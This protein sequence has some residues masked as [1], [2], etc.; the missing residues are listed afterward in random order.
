MTSLSRSMIAQQRQE[1]IQQIV[2]RIRRDG[3][4]VVPRPLTDRLDDPDEH[5][6]KFVARIEEECRAALEGRRPHLEA[7]KTLACELKAEI[8]RHGWTIEWDML[9][10]QHVIVAPME[11]VTCVDCCGGGRQRVP[12]KLDFTYSESLV[13]HSKICESCKGIGKQER[14][15]DLAP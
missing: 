4:C 1:L 3:S 8:E 15:K 9:N 5:P 14:R 13:C 6:I 7:P 2:E 12:I 10:H 11:T